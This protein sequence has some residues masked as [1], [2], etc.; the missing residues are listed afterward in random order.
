MKAHISENNV[1]EIHKRTMVIE[2]ERYEGKIISTEIIEGGKGI[3]LRL[4]LRDDIYGK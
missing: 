3:I 1:L 2:L 4:D